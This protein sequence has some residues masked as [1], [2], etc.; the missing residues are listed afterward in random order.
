MV[1][2]RQTT[3]ARGW[4][5]CGVARE[6]HAMRRASALVWA[7]L[8]LA[9]AAS[10]SADTRATRAG[11]AHRD[12]H[13]NPRAEPIV[14][15]AGLGEGDLTP[16]PFQTAYIGDFDGKQIQ[17]TVPGGSVEYAGGL[18]LMLPEGARGWS[19]VVGSPFDGSALWV[20]TDNYARLLRVSLA[21]D[22]DSKNLAGINSVEDAAWG[23]RAPGIDE[24]AGVKPPSWGAVEPGTWA[25]SS[26]QSPRVGGGPG[27][28]WHQGGR[29]DAES[30]VIV[31]NF[32][33]GQGAAWWNP[34]DPGEMVVGVED[35][36]NLAANNL[37]RFRWGRGGQYADVP[38]SAAV[39]RGSC[40]PNHGPKALVYLPPLY[41]SGLPGEL[42][43]GAAV[44]A[45]CSSPSPPVCAGCKSRVDAL[46]GFLFDLES[47]WPANGP[48]A[49]VKMTRIT[50]GCELTDATA[51]PD[52]RF[53]IFMHRCESDS[54]VQIRAAPMLAFRKDGN[55]VPSRLLF[56]FDGR[57]GLAG[58]KTP[59]HM[60]RGTFARAAGIHAFS[61]VD[62]NGTPVLALAIVSD[63]DLNA[64]GSSPTVVAKFRVRGDV[65]ADP[66][67][68]PWPKDPKDGTSGEHPKYAIYDPP[69]EA[70]LG[71]GERSPGVGA[72]AE[73]NDVNVNE[74]GEK[75]PG[76]L[77]RLGDGP[78]VVR[79]AFPRLMLDEVD[80][81]LLAEADYMEAR[82][83]EEEEAYGDDAFTRTGVGP[84]IRI[85]APTEAD[86]DASMGMGVAEGGDPYAFERAHE[87]RGSRR[88]IER[89]SSGSV[90]RVFREMFGVDE[91]G[92]IGWLAGTLA[93]VCV[94]G[95]VVI[96]AV[97]ADKIGGYEPVPEAADARAG[98][99]R[100][101][102][103]LSSSG[104]GGLR[105]D[106]KYGDD[107]V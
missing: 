49:A 93:G 72:A 24:G 54:S 65:Y 16:V 63:D 74:E 9:S 45:F 51:T 22:P 23:I 75:K 18:A 41:G 107:A 1:T 87:P 79:E 53:A 64:D 46:Q 91:H 95:G 33:T 13:A 97:V 55:R 98:G 71:A 32:A 44:V 68:A 3:N 92:G 30:L 94:F 82:R 99:D 61:E 25:G 10:A 39:L 34:A 89:L 7:M 77:A 8:V 59:G 101:M 36:F 42:K 100:E 48:I 85:V 69:K 28:L 86:Y 20:L 15:V 80:S 47:Q 50:D 67:Q 14:E 96:V 37:V 58:A 78:V 62:E 90:K 2:A 83:E 104:Y 21:L 26:W 81:F 4:D 35:S 88:T 40:A 60:N 11:D 5:G 19:S 102:D 76:R 12:A 105:N 31:P 66:G 84:V 57:N 27:K 70:S 52:G 56:T 106:R 38:G 103:V 29:V 17:T 6:P 43:L 73:T